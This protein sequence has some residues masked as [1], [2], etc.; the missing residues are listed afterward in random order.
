MKDFYK[1][2]GVAE[3]AT[4]SELKTKFRQAAMQYH[5]D[6][7]P[8]DAVAEA[9]FKEINEAYQNLSDPQKRAAHDYE[10]KHGQAQSSWAGGFN[11][12]ES[13]NNQGFGF[14]GGGPGDPHF[15]DIIR[16]FFEQG[17]AGPFGRQQPRHNKHLHA[18][19]EITLE[20]AF[21]GKNVPL[22]FDH[23]GSKVSVLVTIPAGITH[24]TRMRYQGHGEKTQPNLPPGNLYVTIH[25]SEHPVFKRDSLD[26]H[27]VLKINAIDAM[28]GSAVDFTCID[29]SKIAINILAGTQHGTIMRIINKGMPNYQEPNQRGSLLLTVEITIPTNLTDYDIKL[30]TKIAKRIES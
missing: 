20:D 22:V 18:S 30:L 3:T 4:D 6:R 21:N 28:I 12:Q 9:K 15:E 17:A 23:L 27:A 16:Q 10:R 25:I 11:Y 29:G 1:T 2:L 24:G 5:P 19:I 14:N 8:G 26:L 7:N 13:W